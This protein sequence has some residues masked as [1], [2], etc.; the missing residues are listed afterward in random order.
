ME[1]DF[2][3]TLTVETLEKVHTGDLP[4]ERTLRTSE[5]EN[6]QKEQILGRMP[7][8]L[9]TVRHLMEQNKNDFA[10]YTSSSTSPEERKVIH[11]RMVVRRRKM[12]TLCEEL[13]LRHNACNQIMKRFEQVAEVVEELQRDI[14]RL[15]RRPSAASELSY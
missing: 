5:T 10:E 1:S 3:I 13:S 14:Q 11:E 7:H 9:K 15:K 6:V 2:A 4:F 8:N 12:A